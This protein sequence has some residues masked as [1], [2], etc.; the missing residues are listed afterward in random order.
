MRKRTFF[1][2]FALFFLAA[3]EDEKAHT[4]W[5][6]ATIEATERLD[7]AH[8]PYEIRGEEIWI[9]EEEAERAVL[10]CS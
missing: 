4:F 2:L 5:S 9:P 7:D 8:I 3:C 6:D 1:L 10:C